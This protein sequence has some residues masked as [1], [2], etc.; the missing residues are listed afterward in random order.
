MPDLAV[1]GQPGELAK[2]AGEVFR[3]VAATAAAEAAAEAAITAAVQ[4]RRPRQGHPG[5]PRPGRG[6][7]GP[8]GL[9]ARRQAGRAR[10]LQGPPDPAFLALAYADT[11]TDD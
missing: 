4:A 3:R 11:C 8:A 9:R 2:A 1:A 7:D 6:R 5:G 10:H